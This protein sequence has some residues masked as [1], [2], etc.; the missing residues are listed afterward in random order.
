M[1]RPIATPARIIAKRAMTRLHEALKPLLIAAG[2]RAVERLIGRPQR[3]FQKSRERDALRVS[4]YLATCVALDQDPARLLA[5]AL[6]GEVEPEIRRPHIVASAWEKLD[7]NAGPGLGEDHLAELDAAVQARPQQTREAIKGEWDQASREEIPRLLGLYGSCLRIES[8]LARAT[9]VLREALDMTR[10]ADLAAAEPDL[11]IRLAYVAFEQQRPEPAL[12][13]SMEATLGYGC[14]DDREGEGRGYLTVGMFRYYAHDYRRALRDL[15]ASLKR[16]AM[17]RRL[18]SAHHGTALCWLALKNE[19][20]AQ[21]ALARA[22]ELA[23]SVPPW[24]V[25]KLDWLESRLV[26]GGPRLDR[27]T[28]ARSGLYSNRP[29]DCVL[30]TIELIEE[31]LMLERYE[32]AERE[33]MGLC[34]LIDRTS[35]PRIESAVL[36]LIRNRTR[37]TPSLV[38]RV[39]RA[40]EL[41]RDRRLAHLAR[42]E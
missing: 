9:L 6:A 11:L 12:R 41:A 34:A 2:V 22:R 7:G 38:A 8:D 17:P 16:S 13:Y 39:R 4:D 15:D 23:S 18:F 35:S 10:V 25:A 28:A 1:G 37:L 3:F 40:V 31:A 19:E 26:R 30:V 29:A 5:Q 42:S 14:L 24:S 21:L 32:V 20:K 27:L 36:H 33:T